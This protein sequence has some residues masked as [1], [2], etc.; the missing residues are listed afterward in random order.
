MIFTDIGCDQGFRYFITGEVKDNRFVGVLTHRWSAKR[1]ARKLS[2]TVKDA[3][4]GSKRITASVGSSGGKVTW[5][6]RE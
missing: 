4:K 2:V 3:P 1:S 5:T 6:Y